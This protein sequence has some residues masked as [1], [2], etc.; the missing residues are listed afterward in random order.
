M[1][2]SAIEIA[3]KSI[4]Y[5]N[6]SPCGPLT[7]SGLL[8]V[9]LRIAAAKIRKAARIVDFPALFGPTRMLKCRRF[10]VKR[11]KALK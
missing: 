10:S 3:F 4:E 5:P 8:L 7:I 11:L 2:S 9:A 1:F 6:L